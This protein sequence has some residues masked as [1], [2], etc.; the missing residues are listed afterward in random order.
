MDSCLIWR[1]DVSK[2]LAVIKCVGELNCWLFFVTYYLWNPY[3]YILYSY[4]IPYMHIQGAVHK[5]RCT[6]EGRGACVLKLGFKRTFPGNQ[7][8]TVKLMLELI[9]LNFG[10]FRYSCLPFSYRQF[11]QFLNPRNW[12]SL[13]HSSSTFSSFSYF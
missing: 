9:F 10:S 1:E 6:L 11:Y 7:D 3:R 13:R 4:L 12:L 8:A 2:F 5:E